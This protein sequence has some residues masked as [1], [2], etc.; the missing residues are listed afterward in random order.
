M[1]EATESELISQA[2]FFKL[3]LQGDWIPPPGT[4][5]MEQLVPIGRK[6]GKSY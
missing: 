5:E 3:T 4:E 2:N 6:T 1:Q